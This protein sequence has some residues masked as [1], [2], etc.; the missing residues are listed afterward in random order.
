MRDIIDDRLV[1][2]LHLRALTRRGLAHDAARE[3]TAFQAGTLRALMEGHLGGDA[4]IGELLEHGDL[5][6][7]TVQH[8]GGELVIVD[9]EAFL[10]DGHGVVTRVAS[11]TPTPFAVVCRFS[12]IAEVEIDGRV[13]LQGF[14]HLVDGL[15]PTAG[16][17]AAVRADGEFRDLRLRSVHGRQPPYPPLAE[18][19]AHQTQWSV[20]AARGTIVGFRFPD[21][22][23]GVEAPGHHLHFLSEDRADGGHVL[24]MAMTDGRVAIDAGDEL[25]VELP[26]HVRLGTPGVADRAAIHDIEEG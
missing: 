20:Q 1:G 24:D 4:T 15:L 18:I 6:I 11:Q 19:I 12:P 5:G 16:P 10:V 8:V 21:E 3:H 13:D 17:V 2:A 25:H 26:S 14:R 23:A 9:G 7:G 22:I